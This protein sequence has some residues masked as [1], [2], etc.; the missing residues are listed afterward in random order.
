[1]TDLFVF[2]R[3]ILM[4]VLTNVAGLQVEELQ[5]V[6][7]WFLS[8]ESGQTIRSFCLPSSMFGGFFGGIQ[9]VLQGKI[10]LSDESVFFT[11]PGFGIYT[12]KWTDPDCDIEESLWSLPLPE[13]RTEALPIYTEL[14]VSPCGSFVTVSTKYDAWVY[15]NGCQRLPG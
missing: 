10:A 14:D 3:E 12:L 7:F 1:L 13:C 15:S 9:T 2:F 5:P 8:A 4:V 11:G 6:Y